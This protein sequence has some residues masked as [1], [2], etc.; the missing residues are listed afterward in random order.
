MD[1][2]ELVLAPETN[3]EFSNGKGDDEEEVQ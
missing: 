3:E 2:K 1:E